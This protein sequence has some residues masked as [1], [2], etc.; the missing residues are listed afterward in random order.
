MKSGF[1]PL[2]LQYFLLIPTKI[3]ALILPS[4]RYCFHVMTLWYC[5]ILP[6]KLSSILRQM[7]LVSLFKP[8]L[9]LLS[10][11]LR[12]KQNKSASLILFK[13]N[14]IHNNKMYTNVSLSGS[15]CQI[16]STYSTS[17]ISLIYYPELEW[18]FTNLNF[19]YFWQ[20]LIYRGCW[21]HKRL[22]QMNS[23]KIKFLNTNIKG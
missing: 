19:N 12:S 8:I 13:E 5:H 17:S 16:Y 2:P 1:L 3:S 15:N 21:C 20:N 6:T 9:T 4:T 22:R 18:T 11:R 10:L 23:Y 7:P 14:N